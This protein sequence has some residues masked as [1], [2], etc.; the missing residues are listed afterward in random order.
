MPGA[1]PRRQFTELQVPP[2]RLSVEILEIHSN[3]VKECKKM[4]DMEYLK[5]LKLPI[6]NFPISGPG[7]RNEMSFEDSKKMFAIRGE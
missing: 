5:G 3:R 7:F 4:D 6:T 2:S 1:P